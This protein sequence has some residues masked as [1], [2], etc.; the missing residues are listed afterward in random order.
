[1]IPDAADKADQKAA[2]ETQEQNLQRMS[3]AAR[4]GP[5]SEAD[6]HPR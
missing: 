6:A 2:T 1:M 5:K 4:S 3:T